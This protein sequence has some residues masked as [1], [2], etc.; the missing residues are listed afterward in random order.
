M[1]RRGEAERLEGGGCGRRRRLPVGETVEAPRRT[2]AA[3][4]GV[5]AWDRVRLGL[6]G[7]QALIYR[8]PFGGEGRWAGPSRHVTVGGESG[9]L[10]QS[11]SWA[12][13]PGC[14]SVGP[15]VFV[16]C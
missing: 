16:S 10:G 2:A 11:C 9:R 15:A 1:K 5:G 13:V 12:I 14:G 7:G 6:G 3:A 8:R 4:C